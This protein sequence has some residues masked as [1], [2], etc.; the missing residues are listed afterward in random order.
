MGLFA[1]FLIPIGQTPFAALFALTVRANVLVAACATLI[2][3]P[4]TM[5]PIY[6]AAYKVGHGLVGSLAMAEHGENGIWRIGTQ[7]YGIAVP[8][9]LGLL[10][11][12]SLSAIV[13]YF[14]VNLGWRWQIVRRRR[15]KS[16]DSTSHIAG[17]DRPLGAPPGAPRVETSA[18]H[19]RS[20]GT[21]RY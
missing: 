7:V 18:H 11:F 21:M 8:T 6:Y 9:A 12:A 4:L 3:N 20:D 13:G 1:G 16:V 2:T 10:L 19:K 17:R 15:R 14:L 5:P